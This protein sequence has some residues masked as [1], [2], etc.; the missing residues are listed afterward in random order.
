MWSL[1]HSRDKAHFITLICISNS[2]INYQ[3]FA[4]CFETRSIRYYINTLMN[5][6]INKLVPL[7]LLPQLRQSFCKIIF[8][9]VMTHLYVY[10]LKIQDKLIKMRN[11]SIITAEQSNVVVINEY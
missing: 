3:M 11:T 9:S 5:N 6:D 10:K 7:S 8:F 1:I 2:K 4:T